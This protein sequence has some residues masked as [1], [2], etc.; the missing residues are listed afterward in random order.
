MTES[1]WLES[2]KENEKTKM[3]S[4]QCLQPSIDDY[5]LRIEKDSEKID[6]YLLE[7]E[8]DFKIKI[9]WFHYS[10]NIL[11]LCECISNSIESDDSNACWN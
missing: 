4:L 6:D 9:D 8:N 1:F 2:N 7:I 10:F 11:C 3:F 5:L